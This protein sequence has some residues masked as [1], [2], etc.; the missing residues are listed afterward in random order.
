MKKLAVLENNLIIS[1]FLFVSLFLFYT[2]LLQLWLS[3]PKNKTIMIANHNFKT[4]WN[5]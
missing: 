3:I 2:L 5:L 4:I 1:L